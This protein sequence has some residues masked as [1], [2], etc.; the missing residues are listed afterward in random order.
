MSDMI[1]G[2]T[3]AELRAAAERA[4]PGKR[5]MFGES[6]TFAV[7]AVGQG[8]GRIVAGDLSWTDYGSPKGGVVLMDDAK[9]IALWDRETCLAACDAFEQVAALTA[10]NT[11]LAARVQ[12][13]QPIE[14]MPRNGNAT[15]LVYRPDCGVFVAEWVGDDLFSQFGQDHLSGDMPTHWMP[16]PPPPAALLTEDRTHAAN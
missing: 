2:R 7:R 6:A 3:V 10:E 14:T 9:H 13:W 5:E 15:F 11:R 12:E 4:T 8:W 1:N 16:L